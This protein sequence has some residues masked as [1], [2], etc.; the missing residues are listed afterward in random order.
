MER[1]YPLD[2]FEDF[3]TG[4]D[5]EGQL[6]ICGVLLP[7]FTAVIFDKEGD[8]LRIE[9]KRIENIKVRD[10]IIYPGDGGDNNYDIEDFIKDLNISQCKIFIKKFFLDEEYIGIEDLPYH[11]TEE[12]VDADTDFSEREED[13]K[14]WVDSG[15][16]VFNWGNDYHIDGEG[17][18]ISS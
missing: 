4:K 17:T 12:A 11:L 6:I 15:C 8:Y 3:F 16:F 9:R 5:H 18:V 1:K 2:D 13:M 14:D 7:F 10:G